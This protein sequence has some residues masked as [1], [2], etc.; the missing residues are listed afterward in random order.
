MMPKTIASLCFGWW[1]WPGKDSSNIWNMVVACLKWLIWRESNNRTI[2]N[3]VRLVD[4]LNP[5]LVGT[6]FQ[7]DRIWG[8]THRISISKFLPS[9]HISS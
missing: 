7:W 1:N 4:L 6:L 9:V 2:E 8:F 5:I 3:I